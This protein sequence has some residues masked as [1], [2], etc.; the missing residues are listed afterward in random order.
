[1]FS[2]HL[3]S[4]HEPL[5]TFRRDMK[6]YQRVKREQGTIE[7]QTIFVFLQQGSIPSLNVELE[8]QHS[9]FIS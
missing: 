3:Q 6:F 2:L 7:Q 1:M 8:A 5:Q 4:Q 9:A